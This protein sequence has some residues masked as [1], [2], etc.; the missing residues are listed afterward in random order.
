MSIL[1]D[2]K[3]EKRPKTYN[4]LTVLVGINREKKMGKHIR[5]HQKKQEY[6]YSCI[7]YI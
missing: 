1:I 6:I 4:I 2:T 5:I 7:K 3:K